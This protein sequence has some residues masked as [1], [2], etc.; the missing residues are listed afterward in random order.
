MNVVP[1]VNV[2]VIFKH[3]DGTVSPSLSSNE[4]YQDC[5]ADQGKIY[6]NIKFNYDICLASTVDDEFCTSDAQQN[7]PRQLRK[8]MKGMD[9]YPVDLH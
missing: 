8:Q 3:S 4:H 7:E 6:L 9:V 2:T 5:M 1:P